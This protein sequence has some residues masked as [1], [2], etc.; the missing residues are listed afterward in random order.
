MEW[1]GVM[2][3]MVGA[4]DVGGMVRLPVTVRVAVVIL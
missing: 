2:G 1:V 3:V 4:G